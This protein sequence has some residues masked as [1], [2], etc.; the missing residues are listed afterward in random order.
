MPEN[1]EDALDVSEVYRN[2]G[3][4]AGQP[5][6]RVELV[7]AE[8]DLVAA[9]NGVEQLF[10]MA[11]DITKSPEMRLFAAAKIQALWD[12]ATEERRK[13]PD[14]D[15]ARVTARVAGL[16]SRTW[17]SSTDYCSLLCTP[18]APGQPGPVPREVPLARH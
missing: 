3:I 17:Q 9:E 11:G 13:R 15:L 6:A 18:P 14:I 4:F 16:G 7:K 1:A 5:A 10:D 8:I 2:V 12:A